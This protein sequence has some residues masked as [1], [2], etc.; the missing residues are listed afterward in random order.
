VYDYLTKSKRC[1]HSSNP[2]QK[3]ETLRRGMSIALNSNEKPAPPIR[4]TPSMNTNCHQQQQQLNNG[5]IELQS[6][7]KARLKRAEE[8]AGQVDLINFQQQKTTTVAKSMT[9]TTNIVSQSNTTEDDFPPPPP[10]FLLH[11][12]TKSSSQVT[13]NTTTTPHSSLLAEIQR[14]FK[15]RKTVIDRDKSAPRL[16]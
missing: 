16:K 2:V 15:L 5:Y 10:E 11:N 3:N 1:I 14:G 9:Q 12:D 7:L 6:R 8:I 4:R 13:T